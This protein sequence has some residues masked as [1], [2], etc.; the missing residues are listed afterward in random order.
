VSPSNQVSNLINCLTN[1]ED[2]RQNLWIHYLSGNP[3]SSFAS[4]LSKIEREFS[5]DSQIQQTLWDTHSNPKTDKF[6]ELLVNFSEIEQSVLCL[7]ALGLTISE[8]SSYKG[9]S[10]VRIRQLISVVR[11]NECWEEIYGIKE[12]TD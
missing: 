2:Q 9:I 12:K 10:E 5:L 4:Y 7:L 8:I 6:Q 1:D 3:P 11:Y